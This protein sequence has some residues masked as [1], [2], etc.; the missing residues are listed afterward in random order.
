MIPLYLAP[1]AGVSDK[2]F[3]QLCFEHG[4][5]YA[6]TEMVSAK[7]L[8]F[9]NKN[10]EDLLCIG[11]GEGPIGFQLFGHEPEMFAEAVRTLEPRANASIDINMGC[12]VPKVVK[13]FEGSALMNNPKLAQ[14]CVKACVENTKKPV[15]IKMR[16]GF[17][18]DSIAVDFAKMM[19]DAGAS[20]IT[21]HGR[22]REQY[23]SG[24]A[25]WQKIKEVKQAVSIPVVGNGDVF[26]YEDA[27]RMVNETGVDA[28]MIARGAMGNPWIFENRVPEL[29]EIKETMLRHAAMLIDDKGEYAGM[30]QMRAH[31]GHYIKGIKG[32]ALLR[33]KL[34][35]CEQLKDLEAVLK[36]I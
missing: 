18:D 33:A 27:V 1:L 30:R 22:T 28:V 13:N 23:Y 21:V 14:E 3:R 12:P 4:C 8:H 5:K 24:K 29:S 2:S 16:I 31:A 7:G 26:S 11:E 32:A 36:E 6:F 20:M 10:T 34:N 15:S 19:E 17:K 25:N 35:S 9:K